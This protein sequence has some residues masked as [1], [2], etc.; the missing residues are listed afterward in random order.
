MNAPQVAQEVLSKVNDLNI[1]FDFNRTYILVHI[2]SY[3]FKKTDKNFIS[4]LKDC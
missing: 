1:T 4:D 3:M 2:A